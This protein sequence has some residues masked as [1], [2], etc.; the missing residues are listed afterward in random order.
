MS[1]RIMYLTLSVTVFLWGGCSEKLPEGPGT[2]FEDVVKVHLTTDFDRYV[3]ENTYRDDYEVPDG[4]NWLEFNAMTSWLV[5][6]RVRVENVFDEPIVG[7]KYIDA[8]IK[9]WDRNDTTKV[10]TLTLTDTLSS[11]TIII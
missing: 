6:F 5:H 8:T 10:R 2:E 9:I 7:A 11:D 3:Q 1:L 4:M